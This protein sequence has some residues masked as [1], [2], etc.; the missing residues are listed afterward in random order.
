MVGIQ[1]S[2][3]SGVALSKF[4]GTEQEQS[5]QRPETAAQ[6]EKRNVSVIL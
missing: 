4:S 3:R 5:G 2:A 1:W 6:V